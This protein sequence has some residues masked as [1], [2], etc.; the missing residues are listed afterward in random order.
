M[1]TCF[2]QQFRLLVPRIK[3]ETFTL[4]RTSEQDPAF[5]FRVDILLP[6]TRYQVPVP[7]TMFQGEFFWRE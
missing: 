5:S 4:V 3:K 1:N 2:E 7:G 6:G